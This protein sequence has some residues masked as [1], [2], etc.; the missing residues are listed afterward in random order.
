MLTVPELTLM[1]KSEFCPTDTPVSL[2]TFNATLMVCGT[3]LLRTKSQLVRHLSDVLLLAVP[4]NCCTTLEIELAKVMPGRT[5]AKPLT[6]APAGVNA[7]SLL[8][9]ATTA[10]AVVNCT[11]VC[12][13]PKVSV[14]VVGMAPVIPVALLNCGPTRINALPV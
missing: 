2:A 3:P 8:T 1:R 13:A 10:L 6:P 7:A 4:Q 11:T 5:L 14:N 12:V 9:M